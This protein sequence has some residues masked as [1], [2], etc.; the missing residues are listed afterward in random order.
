MQVALGK[1]GGEATQGESKLNTAEVRGG[2]TVLLPHPTLAY[3][4]NPYRDGK[5]QR[6]MTLRPSHAEAA[7][8]LSA[9]EAILDAAGALPPR[10]VGVVTPYTAQVSDMLN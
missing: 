3:I 9:L 1:G 5:G 10:E 7:R 6:G 8:L 2:H 4:E